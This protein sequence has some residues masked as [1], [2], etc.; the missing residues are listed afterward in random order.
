LK[1][2]NDRFFSD[3]HRVVA[4]TFSA[5]RPFTMNISA[6]SIALFATWIGYQLDVQD[7]RQWRDA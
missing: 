2:Q 1:R 6:F 5:L 3:V 4:A 7:C